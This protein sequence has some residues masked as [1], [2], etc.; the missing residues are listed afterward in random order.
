MNI[1][2]KNIDNTI[3]HHDVKKGAFGH[4]KNQPLQ[5]M[6]SLE[7]QNLC[8]VINRGEYHFGKVKVKTIPKYRG[9]SRYICMMNDKDYIVQYTCLSCFESENTDFFNDC[10]F[11][12]RRKF[13][14][15]KI[16]KKMFEDLNSSGYNVFLRM[17]VKSFADNI[18]LVKLK[19]LI[20]KYIHDDIFA[21]Y[22]IQYI[23]HSRL[24][25]DYF[26]DDSKGLITGG[27]FSNF[28]MNLY[29]KDFDQFA[30]EFKNIYYYRYGDDCFLLGPDTST[31]V[32]AFNEITSKLKNE[33][34]LNV[35]PIDKEG[36]SQITDLRNCEYMKF[37]DFEFNKDTIRIRESTI[38]PILEHVA[39]I[40]EDNEIDDA[41]R[42]VNY[43]F[44]ADYDAYAY[45]DYSYFLCF[46]I[47]NNT[48]Q[49]VYLNQS[50]KKLFYKKYGKDF[51][52]QRLS[53]LIDLKKLYFILKR[54]QRNHAK[55]Y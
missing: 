52:K 50:I 27:P 24:S 43:Y 49:F 7:K 12:F 15:S 4:F 47:T 44:V 17:D 38:S 53:K 22:L 46:S 6:S 14:P 28:L 42:L 31:I 23:D 3:N 51:N 30:S 25:I 2:V 39:K 40:I 13:G 37:Y 55:Y 34:D 26:S 9:G 32:A 21:L 1:I 35:Y 10:V 19:E 18:N 29:L 5:K 54:K 8:D 11:A 41:V 36:K 48:S 33:Y 16:V 45:H 20:H